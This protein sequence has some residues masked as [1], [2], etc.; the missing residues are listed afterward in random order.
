MNTEANQEWLKLSDRTKQNIFEETAK[1]VGL[2]NAA[3]V[4]KDWWVVRTLE[5]VFKS[6]IAQHTVFKGGTS[7]SKA[8]GLIDRFSEDIDLAL[9]RSFLGFDKPDQEMTGSQVSKL[10]RYTV[11]FISEVFFPEMQA[12][13][14]DAGFTDVTLKLGE[15]KNPDDDPIIIEIYYKSVTEQIEYIQP[16]VLIEMG[17]RSLI[18]P[19]TDCGF[20]S[21]VGE[22]FEDRSFADNYISI[23]TVN[24]ERTFLEKVFLLHER[25]QIVKEG[26]KV[27]RRSRHL[28]DL[29]KLMDTE[30][31][32]N[33][34]KD[35][36]LYKTIVEHRSKL[37]AERGIDYANHI[38]SKINIIPPVGI[39]DEWEK[40]YKSMQESMLFN[41]SLPFDKL[42]DRIQALQTK[43]NSIIN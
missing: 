9:D 4:E 35:K 1:A 29:E 8:W 41:P 22:H 28:Y 2:P 21:L 37:T 30:F 26:A 31:A 15:I 18:E 24:P 33:A 13:F 12:L 36:V 5:L 43:I 25:F 11:K 40:D 6:S 7:L 38:P 17:S 39:K 14:I 27:E 42:L 16:R 3:A 23:P 34:L 32:Q 10:R 19:F 20:K